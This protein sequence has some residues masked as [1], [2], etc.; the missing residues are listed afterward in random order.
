M[1]LYEEPAAATQYAQY[2]TE[3]ALGMIF[4]TM[5]EQLVIG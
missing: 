3:Q 5:V 2:S 1:P 4:P